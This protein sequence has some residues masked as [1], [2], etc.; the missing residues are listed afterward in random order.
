MPGL[1]G[2]GGRLGGLSGLGGAG[3][4][5]GAPSGDLLSM[6]NKAGPG[7]RPD[8]HGGGQDGPAFDASDFPSLTA[9]G[10]GGQHRSSD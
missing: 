3:S 10:G 4:G 9:A 8:Q 5:Y 6:L 2:L 7:Q 1:S